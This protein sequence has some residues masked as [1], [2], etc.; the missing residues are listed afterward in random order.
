M[1][2]NPDQLNYRQLRYLPQF[3]FHSLSFYSSLTGGYA[4]IIDVAHTTLFLDNNLDVTPGLI[5]LFPLPPL[6]DNTKHERKSTKSLLQNFHIKTY[7][8]TYITFLSNLPQI[9][10][11]SLEQNL[12]AT[13]FGIDVELEQLEELEEAT[14][15]STKRSPSGIRMSL[16]NAEQSLHEQGRRHQKYMCVILVKAP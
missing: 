13:T 1:Q 6:L 9:Y 14:E 5:T 2:L 7:L 10:Y 16:I 8:S 12:N 15:M 4:E 11:P 3:L